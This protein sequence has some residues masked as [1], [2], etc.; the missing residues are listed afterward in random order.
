MRL[1]F[2]SIPQFTS[3]LRQFF[4]QS[5]CPFPLTPNHSSFVIYVISVTWTACA[6]I[7]LLILVDSLWPSTDT[8]AAS[9]IYV[10]A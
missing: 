1:N 8:D 10:S 4:V 6:I 2:Q 7:P 3:C 9:I 5:Q